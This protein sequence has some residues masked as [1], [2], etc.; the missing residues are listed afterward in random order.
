[1]CS[2]EGSSGTS[3]DDDDAARHAMLRLS[4]SVAH[5]ELRA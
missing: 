3:A 2:D 5:R 4:S 1:V